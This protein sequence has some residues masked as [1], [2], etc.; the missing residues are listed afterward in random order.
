VHEYDFSALLAELGLSHEQFIDLCILMKCDYCGTIRGIGPKRALELIKASLAAKPR[1][2]VH[3]PA[4]SSYGAST[5]AAAADGG[6]A[7]RVARERVCA[8]RPGPPAEAR[9]H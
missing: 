4:L 6:A 7:L 2:L 3:C 8:A 9:Q 5:L 1:V